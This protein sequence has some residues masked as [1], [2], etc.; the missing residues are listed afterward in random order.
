VRV[1]DDTRL[2][3]VAKDYFHELFQAKDCVRTPVLNALRQVVTN[4]DNDEL[5]T[6]YR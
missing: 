4:D 5:T 6:P 3:N 1:T 2:A